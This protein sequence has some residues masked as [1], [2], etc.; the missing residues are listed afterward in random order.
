MRSLFDLVFQ[1]PQELLQDSRQSVMN[2]NCMGQI[3]RVCM[4]VGNEVGARG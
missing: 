2:R 1:E 3:Q 4:A